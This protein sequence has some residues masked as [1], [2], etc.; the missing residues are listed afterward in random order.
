VK[1]AEAWLGHGSGLLGRARQL[2]PHPYVTLSLL[3][4]TSSLPVVRTPFQA[5]TFC[6]QFNYTAVLPLRLDAPTLSAL[7]SA[8][9]LVEV[10]H[11]C[12]R[13][14]AVAAA[15]SR[16]LSSSYAMTG[17]QQ[18]LLGSAHLPLQALLTHPQGVQA[19]VVLQS[20]RGVA[21]GAVR[22]EV[23]WSHVG[24]EPL[25]ASPTGLPPL[26]R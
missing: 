2:G 13:S 20:Q 11:H 4:G 18:V 19:W 22:V 8:E 15:L 14:Q 7:G 24:G 23:S 12:P 1:E 9:A 6:P 16:G 17:Q 21:A 3:P 25:D 26:I 5:Q 10:W